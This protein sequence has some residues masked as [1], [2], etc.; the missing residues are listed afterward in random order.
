M[1]SIDGLITN[2]N[3]TQI[4]TQL[5]AVERLPEQQLVTQQATA[6]TTVGLLQGLNS[7]FAKI[8]T[9]A[10]WLV[11]DSLTHESTWTVH[12]ATST[13]PAVATAVA[14][15]QAVPGSMTFAV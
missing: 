9:V 11:P 3:T 13:A 8:Q 2:L 15:Q 4:I 5:M 10:H 7:M 14:G 12:N 6:Q 1:A